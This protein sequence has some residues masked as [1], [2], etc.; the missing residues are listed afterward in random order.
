MS[1]L[2]EQLA[3]L[4]QASVRP[5]S[6]MPDYWAARLHDLLPLAQAND[7]EIEWLKDQLKNDPAAPRACMCMYCGLAVVYEPSQGIEVAIQTMRRHDRE[8][9]Q[10]PLA[11]ALTAIGKIVKEQEVP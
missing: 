4:C 8:C 1:K 7:A 3:A 6:S 5:E 10:N 9:P 2:T 11:Q